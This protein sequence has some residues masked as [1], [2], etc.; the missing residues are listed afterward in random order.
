MA[1]S[2]DELES[3]SHD[4]S[5]A[6]L[7]VYAAAGRGAGAVTQRPNNPSKLKRTETVLIS[8]L[9]KEGWNRLISCPAR[10]ALTDGPSLGRG[11]TAR[12][13]GRNGF[14]ASLTNK[15]MRFQMESTRPVAL[16]TRDK[17]KFRQLPP[18]DFPTPPCRAVCTR[19]EALA[20]FD[21]KYYQMRAQNCP[22]TARV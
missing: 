22:L 21:R 19:P 6:S 1:M 9:A 14:T 11:D 7:L 20:S 18:L 3:V 2:Y 16:T 10:R 12:G 13:V 4:S 17:L 8:D 15:N 5:A